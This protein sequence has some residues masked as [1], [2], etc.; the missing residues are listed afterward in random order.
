MINTMDKQ[1][2]V[3]ML[4][5]N[6]RVS[7]G[8]TSYAMNYFRKVDHS[9]VRIDFAVYKDWENPYESEIKEKGS[10]I[11]VLP[12]IKNIKAHISAC[13]EI[14]KSEKYDI[15]HDN[16]MLITLP[17]MYFSKK[18]VPIRILHSHNSQLGETRNKEIRNKLLLPFLKSQANAY[19]ACSDLAAKAMFGKE[20]YEF[21]PNFIDEEKYFF[22]SNK[23][24]NK[25]RN[26][27]RQS[28]SN[29]NGWSFSITEKSLFCPGCI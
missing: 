26:G 20:K 1:I 14:L 16:S 17:M 27:F 12:P 6:L 8:V 28:E 15:I 18:Y 7:N 24:Q 22:D 21:I 13:K 3:L 4:L 5:P 29:C 11:Y 2:R 19:A 10:K 23:R 25:S 9:H